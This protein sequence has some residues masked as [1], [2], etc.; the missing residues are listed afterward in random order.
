MGGH[1]SFGNDPN[2]EPILEETSFTVTH[3][4]Q[5]PRKL[6]HRTP[7]NLHRGLPSLVRVWIAQVHY[8]LW[9]GVRNSAL[10]PI[11]SQG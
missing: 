5:N 1:P 7:K 8:H 11:W 2:I 10:T 3:R 4:T 9:V 6:P